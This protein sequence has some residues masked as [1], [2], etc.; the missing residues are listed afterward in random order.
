MNIVQEK[1]RNTGNVKNLV[2]SKAQMFD[3]LLISKVHLVTKNQIK[4]RRQTLV[5]EFNRDKELELIKNIRNYG[6]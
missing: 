3:R 4:E 1:F 5:C 6:R 2:E